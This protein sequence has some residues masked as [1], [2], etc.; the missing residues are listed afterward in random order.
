M[1][2]IWLFLFI[3]GPVCGCPY[4]KV[5]YYFQLLSPMGLTVVLS[6]SS[7]GQSDIGNAYS[8]GPSTKMTPTLWLF[9]TGTC[10]YGLGQVLLI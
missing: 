2:T 6:D 4:N 3:G 5:P 8:K 10:Y 9:Y 1:G 7:N